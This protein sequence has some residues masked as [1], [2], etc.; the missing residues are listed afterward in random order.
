MGL[1][2]ALLRPGSRP[3]TQ[4]SPLDL[5]CEWLVHAAALT[6]AVP[7]ILKYP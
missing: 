2:A 6:A 3:D 1:P 5:V 7:K 4:S